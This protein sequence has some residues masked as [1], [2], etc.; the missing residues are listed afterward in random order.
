MKSKNVDQ[1]IKNNIIISIGD[2]LHRFPN[3][4]ELFH[5]EIFSNLYDPS[6]AVRK[7][8]LLVLTHLVLND[9]IKSRSSLAHIPK[10]LVDEEPQIPPMV[11]YFL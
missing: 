5:K 2:L 11:R 8:T 6:F 4:V 9:M 10:L 7:I 3:T 1:T